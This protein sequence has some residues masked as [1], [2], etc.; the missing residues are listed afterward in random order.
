MQALR[1]LCHDQY[2]SRSCYCISNYFRKGLLCSSLKER[3]LQYL[4]SSRNYS[5]T[6]SDEST[7]IS[8][9]A[10]G[11]EEVAQYSQP[12]TKVTDSKRN[13]QLPH[14]P[15]M[16]EEVLKYLE[17]SA[18]KTYIDMTFGAGG[19]STRILNSA[20]GIKIF[21]LD[22]DPVAY[23]YAHQLSKRYPGQVIPLLGK[24]SELPDLLVQHKIGINSIDGILFDFGCSSMQFDVGERGF[25]IAKDGPLD[26]RMGG[27]CN[28]S[29]PT[30]ADVLEWI[31]EHD[32][33]KILRF[34]GE[35][36]RAKKIAR[37]IINARFTIGSLKTTH[38]LALLISTVLGNSF[39]KDKLGRF[40][41]SA[42]KTFQAL[43]IFVN[44]ELNEINYGIILA[45]TYLK[46]NG[47]LITISFHSLE[48]TIVKR[49]ITG[50]VD[51]LMAN[52]LPAKLLY[53]NISYD[54]EKLEQLLF[55]PWK[56][57][58][59]HV[60]VPTKSEIEMNPRARSAKFRAVEKIK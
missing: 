49:H 39:Q 31:E 50:N 60:L 45:G 58:H 13:K 9:V 4:N 19:H 32:L 30:A 29:E 46:C 51:N 33:V 3:D 26:M 35:E 59:K 42:T 36:R 57:L 52:K 27:P 53:R 43:R 18:G 48:D 24:F 54:E 10:T 20:P 11:V 8:D 41:H 16:V 56:M 21:V 5:Q 40:A 34:Y 23:E 25:S 12:I 37:E 1:N 55:T 47:R 17:P 38:Q 7:E 28:S 2:V 6:T 14:N 22:R 44:N 15:V